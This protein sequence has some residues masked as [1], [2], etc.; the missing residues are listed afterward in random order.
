VSDLIEVTELDR[1]TLELA[2]A[3]SFD[4]R[5]SFAHLTS[6]SDASLRVRWTEWVALVAF[7]MRLICLTSRR[8]RDALTAPAWYQE[9]EH[10]NWVEE[11]LHTV[12]GPIS[13]IV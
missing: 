4:D 13:D 7:A 8:E 1:W 5:W 12:S 3:R 2:A 9:Q 6:Q 11:G 10:N